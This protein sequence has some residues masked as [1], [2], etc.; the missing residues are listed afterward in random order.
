PHLHSFPTRRSSDLCTPSVKGSNVI[1]SSQA[2]SRGTATSIEAW[3]GSLAPNPFSSAPFEAAVAR[4]AAER[5]PRAATSA[6][7][8]TIAFRA[9][10]VAARAAVFTGC[11][12]AS[13]LPGPFAARAAAF[14]GFFAALA[15]AFA[16]R[17]FA[18]VEAPRARRAALERCLVAVLAM[19]QSD[20]VRM[21]AICSA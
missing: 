5:T 10:S 4:S 3:I 15:A 6:V 11:F 1:H 2:T 16:G 9:L 7:F 14:A 19:S 17:L 21:R 8:P 12:T 18:D 13:A 20:Q